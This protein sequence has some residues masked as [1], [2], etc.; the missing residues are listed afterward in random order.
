VPEKDDRDGA[1]VKLT[2]LMPVYN[3]AETVQQVLK[4]LLDVSF[5]C[6]I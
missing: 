6:P 4:R 1:A 2:I 5:P 3:E